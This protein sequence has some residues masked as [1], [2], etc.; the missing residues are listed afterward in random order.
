MALSPYS[1]RVRW[2]YNTA[3]Y[4]LLRMAI[5]TGYSQ[6]DYHTDNMLINE[7]TRKTMIIDFGRC[8]KIVNHNE[9]VDLWN[10]PEGFSNP[11]RRIVGV[12]KE[13]NLESL[14]EP[15]VS[16]GFEEPL[17]GI[18]KPRSVPRTDD[19]V[20]CEILTKEENPDFVLLLKM[21]FYSTFTD[22]KKDDEF[23]W[24]KGVDEEDTRI[25]LFLHKMHN[26]SL[27]KE[28]IDDIYNLMNDTNTYNGICTMD[29]VSGGFHL[30]YHI[31]ELFYDITRTFHAFRYTS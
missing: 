3:R 5:D 31:S 16:G 10:R 20:C 9:M 30:F 11:L 8:K 4:D 17:R 14:R 6:A 23:M 25:L 7:K 12:P 24:I 28:R 13:L 18:S 2:A 26:A 19:S 29:N 21:L 22:E 27:E 15:N 1:Q